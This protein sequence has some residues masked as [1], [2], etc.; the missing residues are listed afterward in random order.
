MPR[1]M[2]H[3]VTNSRDRVTSS[4]IYLGQELVTGYRFCLEIEKIEQL[5]DLF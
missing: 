1:V 5:N 4:H 3:C 2:C